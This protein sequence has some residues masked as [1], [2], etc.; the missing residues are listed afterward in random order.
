MASY[1]FTADAGVRFHGDDIVFERAPELDS[2]DGQKKYRFVT[3]DPKTAARLRKLDSYGI[4]EVT[5]QK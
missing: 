1:T 4:A 3:A 5:D 2:G